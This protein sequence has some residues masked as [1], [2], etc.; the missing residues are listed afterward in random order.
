MIRIL[1]VITTGF[2][3][4]GG[5]TSVMMNYW[6]A[7]DKEDLHFDFA[8]TNVP[9]KE[10]LQEIEVEDCRY[11]RLPKRSL[12]FAYFWKLRQLCKQY[13][14][15]HVH[16]N[17]ATSA[18][19]LLAAKVAGVKKR[20]VH[21]HNSII[22]HPFINKILLPVFKKSYTVPLACSELAGNFLFGKNNFRILRNAIDVNKYA[23]NAEIRKQMRT[24]LGISDDTT[25][26]GHVG[27]FN[28]QKNYPFILEIFK[29]CLNLSPKFILLLIGT[30]P[31]K[32]EFEERIVQEGLSD[33]VILPG[34]RTDISELMSAMDIFLFPSLWEGLPLSALE[35]QAS[36]LPVFLSD[37]ISNEV[38]ASETVCTLPLGKK[39]KQ[40]A[41]ELNDYKSNISRKEQSER[42]CISLGEKG[43]NIHKETNALRNIYLSNSK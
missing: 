10:L 19:E 22:E 31:Q 30:G 25:V 3:P 18:I 28:K 14:V 17:S 16:G 13:D 32:K 38:W 36:G 1:V 41:Q 5:L 37:V 42:N 27:K 23:F 15:I 35:A 7:M 24:G 2:T 21:N 33:K 43:Y 39:S 8:S 6:R 4:I 20:I 12:V 11:Y 9:A 26:I 34:A 40:W 29:E